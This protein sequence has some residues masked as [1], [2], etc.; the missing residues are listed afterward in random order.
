[1]RGKWAA[2]TLVLLASLPALAADLSPAERKVVTAIQ[3]YHNQDVA[4]LERLVN[5]NSGTLNLPGVREIGRLYGDEFAA[6]GLSTRWIPME[7]AGRAGHLVAEH[8]GGG[9]KRILLIAHLDTVFEP[10]SPFQSFVRHGDSAEGP[11]TSDIKGGVVVILAALRGLKTAGLLRHTDLTVFLTGN[12]ERPGQPLALARRDLIAAGRASDL[13][14][15]FEAMARQDGQDAIHIGR[16]SASSWRLTTSGKSGHSSGVGRGGGYGAVYELARIIDEFRRELPEANL[17]FNTS[18]IAGGAT[19]E[20]DAS[21]THAS[22]S[23][24]D[25]IIAAVAVAEGDLRSLSDQQTDRVRQKMQAIVARSLDGAS[26]AISFTEGY[27]AMAP[28][29]ASQALFDQLQE[30][31]HD[32]GLP[33]LTEGDPATRGAGDIAFVARDVPG[34]VGMG[35]AG[36]GAHTIGESVDLSSLSPQAERAALLILRLSAP[37]R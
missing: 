4:L 2:P 6:L 32:L 31:D 28:S 8:H 5:V 9:G 24:K 30:V 36:K 27:P 37:N 22:A 25:N 14:L 35:A 20:L 29:A 10:D 26:A 33:P 1:M 15:D 3:S 11:G 34:L 19:A 7:E 13:A 17:T 16:R 18:L 23:G 12:E 21:V